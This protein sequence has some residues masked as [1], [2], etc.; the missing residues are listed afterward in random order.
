MINMNRGMQEHLQHQEVRVTTLCV[1]L[2]TSFAHR[3]A[4]AALSKH[5]KSLQASRTFEKRVNDAAELYL[6]LEAA[7]ILA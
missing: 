6:E 3:M 5:R 7:A 2:L 4:R 1:T